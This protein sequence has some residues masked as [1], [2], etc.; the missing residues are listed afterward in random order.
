MAS[1]I[2]FRGGQIGSEVRFF[3]KMEKTRKNTKKWENGIFRGRPYRPLFTVNPCTMPTESLGPWKPD[4]QKRPLG[5]KSDFFVFFVIFR[6]FSSFSRK[7]AFSHF[8]RVGQ[9]KKCSGTPKNG[10][11]TPFSSTFGYVFMPTH[12]FYHIP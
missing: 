10:L 1:Q 4:F 7:S 8:L 9:P 12:L 3:G 5:G 11:W 2:G 6:H